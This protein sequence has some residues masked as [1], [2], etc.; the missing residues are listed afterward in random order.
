MFSPQQKRRRTDTEP[1]DLSGE[2]PID[3]RPEDGQE[4]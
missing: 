1:I 4:M 3:L 2:E